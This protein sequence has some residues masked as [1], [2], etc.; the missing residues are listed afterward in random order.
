MY[1]ID[2]KV[3]KL[4]ERRNNGDKRLVDALEEMIARVRTGEIYGMVAA[5]VDPEG[6]CTYMLS[7]AAQDSPVIAAA[8]AGRLKARVDRYVMD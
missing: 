1:Q 4:H 8:V 6:I 3:V 5:F 7:G 2:N